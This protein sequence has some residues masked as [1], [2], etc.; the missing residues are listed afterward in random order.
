MIMDMRNSVI[1]SAFYRFAERCS[2]PVSLL[3]GFTEEIRD[4][5]KRRVPVRLYAAG[6]RMLAN[7]MGA[8]ARLEENYLFD[9]RCFAATAIAPGE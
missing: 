3:D 4:S 9:T 5:A 2:M 7:A 1:R 6:Q 8:K